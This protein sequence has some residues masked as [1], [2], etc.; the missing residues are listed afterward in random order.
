MRH[1]NLP[2]RSRRGANA[3]EFGLTFPVFLAITFAMIEFGWYFSRVALVNSAALDGCRMGA[4]VDD[5]NTSPNSTPANGTATQVAQARMTALLSSGGLNCTDC[6]VVEVGAFPN[7]AIEC[8][9]QVQFDQVTGLFPLPAEITTVSR[10][11][12][13]WQRQ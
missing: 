2:P 3:M 9:T 5:A 11:R 13:E 7:L 4:L 6:S 8:T 12:R 10:V 1:S